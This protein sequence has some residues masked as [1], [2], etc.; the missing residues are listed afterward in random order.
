MPLN[1]NDLLIIGSENNQNVIGNK[2]YDNDVSHGN[3]DEDND[4][5]EPTNLN[6]SSLFGTKL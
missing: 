4:D 6:C 1:S 2:Q 5:D 3:D